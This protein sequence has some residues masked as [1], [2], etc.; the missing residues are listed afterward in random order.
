MGGLRR[1]GGWLPT[2]AFARRARLHLAMAVALAGVVPHGAA[3]FV[4]F[5]TGQVRPLALTPDGQTLLALNTPD[6]RLEIFHVA[7]GDIT[8]AGAVEVGLEPVAVAART[9]T[10]VWVTNHLSDSVSI[11]DIGASPP[12]VVRTLLV[13]DEPSDVVFAGPTD[14]DGHFTRAFITTAR[15]GQNLPDS[16]PPNLTTPGTPRALVYVFDATNLGSSL[17]GTPET[18]VQLFGDTPRAL[19]AS[20]DGHTVYAAIFKS[21]NETTTVTEAAVCD[22]GAAA[23]PCAVDGVQVPGGLPNGQVPGGLPAPNVN[24]EDIV[25]PEVGLIVKYDEASGLW[26][27]E[28]GRNWNNAVRFSLPDLDVFRIDALAEPPQQTASFAHVGTVL[29]NMIVNPTDGA[30]YVSNTEARNEIR[31]EGPGTSASTVRGDLHESRITVIADGQVSPRHLN[32]HITAL[33]QGYRTTPMPDGIKEASL[34]TPLDMAVASD[35]TLYLA[36][37]GSSAVGVFHSAEVEADTFVPDAAHHITVSGGG[38]SGLVLDEANHRL[39]VLTRFDNAVKVI[40][41]VAAQE[42]FQHPLFNPEPPDVVA[43]RPFLYDAQLTSSN[44]EAS[45]ASCHAFANFDSLAWDLGNPDGVETQNFNLRGPVAQLPSPPFSPLK[46]PMTTQTLRGLVNQHSMHW[47]GDRFGYRNGLPDTRDST[48]AFEAFNVAFDSLL[49]RDAGPLTDDQMAAFTDFALQIEPPPNPVRALDNQLTTSQAN[50]QTLFQ[51]RAVVTDTTVNC[52]ECHKLEA[53]T[54]HFGTFGQ[55]TFDDEPQQFKVPQLKNAY[56]KVGMFGTPKTTFFPILPANA[57]FQGDQIRG[58]GFTH[59]GSTATIFDF[60]RDRIFKLTDEQR[61]DMEQFVLA[62]DTTFA[63]IVGQQITL[64][65]ENAAVAGPRIDLLIARARTPFVLINQPHAHECDLIA[66][67]VAGGL[68]R[69]YLFDPASATF[70]GDRVAEPPLTDAQLRALASAD[71]QQLTYTCV[72][73][74]EGVRL[75]IDRDGDGIYDQDESDAS[76]PAPTTTPTPTVSPAPPATSTPTLVSLTPTTTTNPT[77]TVRSTPPATSTVMPTLLPGDADCD[78]RL[79]LGDTAA[80]CSAAFNVPTAPPCGA[81]CNGDGVVTAAD[82][83]CL[84]KLLTASS[85]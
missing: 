18:I 10:E 4:T 49:G 46:G 68:E 16:I 77:L 24:V 15:R 44:G 37:F 63:P 20:P 13:G 52:S 79:N 17:G 29:Y 75:G 43:G 71:D 59:D 56:E 33:P 8:P 34:A 51:D 14:A 54:G 6:A 23:P 70:Q 40:D 38:P 64:T 12:H 2:P 55:T 67:G 1:N 26:K 39:Y 76:T 73:P 45:C 11:V 83:T 66:K 81:D 62:F 78:G 47:R 21:G 57:Q 36:A 9:S 5:E 41:T 58:F 48:L 80:M 3:A 31:F 25:G 69:G 65:G 42:L 74:G 35:G 30:L 82:V 27:D 53:S 19:A 7:G 61:Q 72:P 84:V 50:G 32:K 60:F 28:L 85:Q 22:G